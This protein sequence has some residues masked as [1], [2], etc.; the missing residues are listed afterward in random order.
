MLVERHGPVG[1][2]INNRPNQ[3]NAMN[4]AMRD[5]FAGAWIELDQDPDVRVIVHTGE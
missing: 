3:L 1:W 2:L 4:A 5:E